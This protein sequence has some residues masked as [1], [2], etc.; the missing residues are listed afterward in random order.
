MACIKKLTSALAFDC[1]S[2]VTGFKSALFFNKSDLTSFSVTAN[3]A[4]IVVAA[5][6]VYKIDT[7]KRSIVLNETLK[8]NEEAPNAFTHEAIINIFAKGNRVIQNDLRNARIVICALGNDNNVRVYGL[9]YG[10]KATAST[11]SSHD[12]GGWAQFTLATP[13]GVVGEDS[14][15][16]DK[17]AYDT[18]YTGASSSVSGGRTAGGGTGGEEKDPLG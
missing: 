17:A 4:T 16:M 6:N 3:K 7:V 10:L 5:A 15:Y 11:E 1:E 18:L 2:G 8:V 12:N 13:E 14:L 9:F